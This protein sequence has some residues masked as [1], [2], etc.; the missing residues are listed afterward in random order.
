MESKLVKLAALEATFNHFTND[1]L[2]PLQAVV[3]SLH[4]SLCWTCRGD[5]Q[6]IPDGVR[7]SSAPPR[8]SIAIPI[9]PPGSGQRPPTPSPPP[10]SPVTSDDSSLVPNS[11]SDLDDPFLVTTRTFYLAEGPEGFVWTNEERAAMQAFFAQYKSK[12][13]VDVVILE[14]GAGDRSPG[15]NRMFREG[16]GLRKEEMEHDVMSC[17][18]CWVHGDI[19]YCEKS[20]FHPNHPH[21]RCPP[22]QN[23][24]CLAV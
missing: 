7:S 20:K 19:V 6:P 13:G 10:L 11:S 23:C 1:H 12:T 5:G 15:G 24:Y 9:P 22:W 8:L 2:I 16:T 18:D 4:N 3:I 17:R 14:A 21:H